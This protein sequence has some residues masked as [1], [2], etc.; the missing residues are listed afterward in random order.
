LQSLISATG[1]A[2]GAPVDTAVLHTRRLAF[3]RDNAVVNQVLD[4]SGIGV[5]NV[6]ETQGMVTN[7]GA[8]TNQDAL[9]VLA[10]QE[11]PVFIGPVHFAV[12]PGVLSNTLQV[13]LVAYAYVALLGARLPASIGKATGTGLI[14]PVFV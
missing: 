10:L 1:T 14:P 4:G 9:L 11:T 3:P 5:P 8:G 12:M 6:I 7:L 13:R 2:F